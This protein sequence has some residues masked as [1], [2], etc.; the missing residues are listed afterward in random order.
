M[1]TV[2]NDF[3]NKKVEELLSPK[4]APECKVR[5]VTAHRNKTK[6]MLRYARIGGIAAAFVIAVAIG[7]KSVFVEEAKAMPSPL[8]SIEKSLQEFYNLQS[9]RIKFKA[10]NPLSDYGYPTEGCERTDGY[11]SG[12]LYYLKQKERSYM[13]IEW[14]DEKNTTHI[15]DGENERLMQGE[16]EMGE[17]ISKKARS[18]PDI[19]KFTDK[20]NI[21]NIKPEQIQ[22]ITVFKSTGQIIIELRMPE[23]KG[24][25]VLTFTATPKEGKATIKDVVIEKDGEEKGLLLTKAII[26]TGCDETEEVIF[27]TDSIEYNFPITKELILSTSRLQ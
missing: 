6:L 11:T 19:I 7:I 1:K 22:A 12:T 17:I 9:I 20:K 10:H 21:M 15:S 18:L 16:E 23:R 4:H 13:R 5:F 25:F 26:I 2:D 3:E 8:T 14:D 24:K 27:E